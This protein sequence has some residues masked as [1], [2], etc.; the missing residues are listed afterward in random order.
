MSADHFV[1]IDLE[2][3]SPGDRPT[4]ICKAPDDAMCRALWTCE[5][6]EWFKSGIEGGRPWHAPGD[7]SEPEYERHVGRFDSTECIYRDW[8]E[9]SDECLRGI[10]TIPV[11]PEHNG[12]HVLFHAALAA[13]AEVPNA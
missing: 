3:W 4:L 7:Y 11:T 9:N 8:A 1:T 2:D 13:M 6:E 10:V 5:C 12:D